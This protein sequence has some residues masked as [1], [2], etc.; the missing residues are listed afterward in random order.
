M[1][2]DFIYKKPID[3]KLLTTCLHPKLM[4]DGSIVRM[5]TYVADK[6][7]L[8]PCDVLDEG[9]C[10]PQAVCMSIANTMEGH[11]SLRMAAVEQVC[12]TYWDVPLPDGLTIGHHALQSMREYMLQDRYKHL[13]CVSKND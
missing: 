13:V 3:F 8:Y 2:M 11:K 1:L 10:M 4:L 12:R 9:D 5:A 6:Y 7:N